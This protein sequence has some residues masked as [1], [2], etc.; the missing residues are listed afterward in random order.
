MQKYTDWF[1]WHSCS[2]LPNSD[3]I[4]DINCRYRESLNTVLKGGE[5]GEEVCLTVSAIERFLSR[6]KEINPT[7]N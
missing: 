4:I 1:A 7:K 2:S 6:M 3:I 5:E